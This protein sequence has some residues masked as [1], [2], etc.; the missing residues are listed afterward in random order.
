MENDKLI[1]LLIFVVFYILAL[2]RIVKMAYVSAGGVALILGLGVLT[3][4]EALF[5]AV[6]WDVLGIYWGFMMVSHVFMKS[7]CRI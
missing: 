6:K 4:A 7:R 1:V 5:K 3:P 2:S